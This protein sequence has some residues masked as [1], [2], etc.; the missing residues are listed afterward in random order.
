MLQTKCSLNRPKLQVAYNLAQGLRRGRG[1]PDKCIAN[2][3]AKHNMIKVRKMACEFGRKIDD[4]QLR[5]IRADFIGDP[6]T[7][8]V[9]L[10]GH[11]DS[12]AF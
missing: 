7:A 9:A 5:G 10:S 3:N 6:S 12:I 1:Y 4:F 2:H 11:T 8:W